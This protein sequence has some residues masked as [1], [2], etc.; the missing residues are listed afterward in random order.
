M[1]TKRTLEVHWNGQL[2]GSRNLTKSVRET[3]NRVET[4]AQNG[5]RIGAKKT[6]EVGKQAAQRVI[7]EH[8]AIGPD[9][10]LLNS[11]RSSIQGRDSFYLIAGYGMDE[12]QRYPLLIESGFAKHWMS[13]DD[14]KFRRWLEFKGLLR[15]KKTGKEISGLWVGTDRM[16]WDDGIGFMR[17][18]LVDMNS[19]I[20]KLIMTGVIE[21]IKKSAFK[22]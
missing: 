9:A 5:V 17:T 6:L 1:V 11:I 8:R 18:A 12:A 2:V 4:A 3:L 22:G 14:P 7:R 21:G 10:I 19:K 16:K 15:S 20:N 13:S